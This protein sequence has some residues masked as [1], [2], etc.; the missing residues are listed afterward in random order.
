METEQKALAINLERDIYGT[1]AEIGAGQETARHF[2]RAGG[3]SGTIAKT[4]S[5]YDKTYSDDIY[6]PEPSGRYVCES[7]IYKMLDH[8]FELLINRLE[9]SR[10]DTRFFAFANT[11]AA[12]NFSRTI[13]GD[14]WLGLRFQMKPGG[15]FND[16]ILHARLLDKNN[17]LQQDAVGRLGV[18]LIYGCFF[19]SHN[20]DALVMSLQDGLTG[21]ISV[22]M[23]R[24][25]G[26][27]FDEI[28]NR[29]LSFKLVNYGLSDIAMIGPD[30]QNLHPSEF[31]Y[32]QHVLVVRGAFKPVTWMNYDII[33]AAAD[34]YLREH[35]IQRDELVI[36]TEITLD[37][38][39]R[40]HEPDEI[41]FL[42]RV[43]MLSHLGFI[44]C[45][46]SRG[47]QQKIIRYLDQY[48]V[49]AIGVALTAG[50]LARYLDNVISQFGKDGL[51][52]QLGE[53]FPGKVRMYVYPSRIPGTTRLM[54]TAEIKTDEVIRHLYQYLL[55]SRQIIDVTFY[56]PDV[57][58][59]SASRV[60]RMIRDNEPG[61]EQFIPDNIVH[62]IK[63][64]RLLDYF[65][66]EE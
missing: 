60:L 44:V 12:I 51:L 20:M 32:K 34:Q 66:E 38:L 3:S 54:T 8:E 55:S 19:H 5:A 27:D 13:K 7:R 36:L 46:S 49:P 26:P 11:V 22:D 39:A 45:I 17:Q 25:T 1:I 24:L 58:K 10:P 61:W 62:L 42:Q 53:M 57:L 33:K 30:G 23:I 2:F 63:T 31:L 14:G 52:S 50:Y 6:G 9:Q 35:Q 28:D 59:I 18:N 29:S 16:L 47:G 43:E 48:R 15:A 64:Q 65:P 56:D 41:D 40:E 4:M 21:R 37:I